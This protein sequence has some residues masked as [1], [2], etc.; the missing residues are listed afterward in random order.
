MNNETASIERERQLQRELNRYVQVLTEHGDPEQ[1]I[2]FG[3]LARGRIHNWSDIDL[4]I[5]EDTDKPFL[6]RLRSVRRLLRP[7]VG[8]D[9][10][11]YT[12]EEF[13]RMCGERPFF[14]D[15]ILTKG[16]VVYERTG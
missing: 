13:E 7:Q 5:V 11:V 14:Q 3:S 8:T 4:L 10:L 12:P 9:I 6:Q 2:L 1:I 16:V 15:E